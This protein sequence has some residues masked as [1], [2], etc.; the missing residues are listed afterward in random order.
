MAVTRLLNL[1]KEQ[2]LGMICFEHSIMLVKF[3]HL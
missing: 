2:G 3:M 1:I